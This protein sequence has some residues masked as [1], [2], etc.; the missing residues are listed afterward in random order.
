[1]IIRLP[2]DALVMLIGP[3]GA[4]K[5]TFAARHFLPSEILASDAMRAIVADDPHD[6]AATEAA[7]ELLHVALT[8]RLARRRLTVVDATN[9]ERWARQEPLA[10]ARRLRRP[11]VAVV[12]DLPLAVCLAHNA[13]REVPRPVPALRR[14]H[15]RLRESI[16]FLSGEGFAEVW[17]LAS[18]AEVDG[19]RI[20]RSG[21]EPAS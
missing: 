1:V 11:A 12:L 16:G 6:Q 18:E 3:S 20:E 2:S 13:A 15:R 19:V 10:I 21:G 14:Q 5:S 7:F 8:L 4:G 17:T 9:V